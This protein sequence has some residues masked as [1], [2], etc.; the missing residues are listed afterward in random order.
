MEIADPTHLTVPQN[1][2]KNGQ[3]EIRVHWHRSYSPVSSDDGGGSFQRTNK[4][5]AK[6][7]PTRPNRSRTPLKLSHMVV[8]C[9]EL[10]KHCPGTDYWPKVAQRSNK[11]CDFFPLTAR[12]SHQPEITVRTVTIHTSGE[13]GN[14]IRIIVRVES[15][16]PSEY[17]IQD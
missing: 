9:F 12:H 10:M 6:I 17:H 13:R 16:H 5:S 15:P 2:L 4:N 8:H 7:Y 11:T 3:A 14:D 1:V